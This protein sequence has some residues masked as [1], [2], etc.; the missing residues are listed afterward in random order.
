MSLLTSPRRRLRALFL[1]LAAAA[2]ASL[3]IASSA[4]AAPASGEVVLTPERL[5]SVWGADARLSE[6]EGRTAL[7]VAWLDAAHG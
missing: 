2:I 4:G 1:A 3:A 5:A 7:H 6:H